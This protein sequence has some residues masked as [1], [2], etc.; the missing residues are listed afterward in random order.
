MYKLSLTVTLLAETLVNTPVLG[1]ALPTLPSN[2]PTKA[3]DTLGVSLIITAPVAVELA[4]VN[5]NINLSLDS[6]KPKNAFFSEPLL[7]KIPASLVGATVAAKPLFKPINESSMSIFDV[8]TVV[9]VPFTVK[10]P[11]ITVL[12][13]TLKPPATFKFSPIPTPPV[14][15][16]APLA[17]LVLLVASVIVVKPVDDNVLNAAAAGT[18][19]PMEVPSMVPLLISTLVNVAFVAVNVAS[20]AIV[21]LLSPIVIAS[22]STVLP[23]VLPSITILSTV[24]PVN[25]PT[26]VICGCAA[27][28]PNT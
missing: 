1:L 10:L 16:N 14:T 4:L 18:F 21:T 6:S 19:E 7:I 11:L 28:T 23:I 9:V 22:G 15:T 26:L 12:P 17:E 27:F 2:D 24:K 8:F 25:V 3:P 20:A 13:P 5:P